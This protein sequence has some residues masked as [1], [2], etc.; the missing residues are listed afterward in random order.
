MEKVYF[1][2]VLTGDIC[3]HEASNVFDDLMVKH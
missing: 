3:K 1:F 2:G